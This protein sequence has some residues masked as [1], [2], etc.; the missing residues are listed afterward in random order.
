VRERERGVN[1]GGHGLFKES[2]ILAVRKSLKDSFAVGKK[3]KCTLVQALRLCTGRTAHRWSRGIALLIL[4]H[5]T[6]RG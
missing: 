3:L 5:G 4:D 1:D 6:R 2:K